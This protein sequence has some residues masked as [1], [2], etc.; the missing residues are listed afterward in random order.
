VRRRIPRHPVHV[1]VDAN[2][3][4]QV[5]WNI[6]DNSL[7]AMPDGGTL[8]AEIAGEG[9]YN[10]S[11]VLADTGIGFTDAQLEK[12]FEPFQT[13]FANGTGLGLAI[14]YQIVQAHQGRI[15]VGSTPG[16]GS[17][18]LIELP[19]DPREGRMVT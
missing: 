1:F 14:V 15:Q 8:T 9:S 4:R 18:F 5:F 2:K 6:C 3:I 13:G 11:I 10:V 12:L 17:R 7:K 16:I 19:R